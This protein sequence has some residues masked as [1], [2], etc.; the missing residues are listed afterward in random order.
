MTIGAITDSP[1]G[2]YSTTMRT[3]FDAVCSN[4]RRI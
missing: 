3:G 2:P 1:S 4:G